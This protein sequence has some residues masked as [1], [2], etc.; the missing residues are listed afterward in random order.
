MRP[1]SINLENHGFHIHK[2]DGELICIQP[3]PPHDPEAPVF[4]GHRGELHQVVWDFAKD[5]LGIP[6]HLG[7]RVMKYFEDQRQA[8]IELDDGEVVTADCVIGADGVRSRARELVLGYVDRPKS[9]GYAIFRAWFGNEKMKA[10]PL[11]RKYCESGDTFQGWI[12]PDVHFLFSTIK[13]GEDCCW[14]LTHKDEKDIEESWSF[15]GKLAD[16]YKVIEGWDPMCKRIVEKTPEDKLVDW[17][18]VYRDPLPRWI[19]GL[20]RIALLGD[21][22]HPFLPTSVQGATQ[23]MEDGVTI[24]VCLRRAGR[25]NIRQALWAY[26]NLRSVYCKVPFRMR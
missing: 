26:Q 4:N 19:S 11:T 15:P 6:I 5:E 13:G 14:V 12:G 2:Y 20:G 1:L 18:L 7:K 8:G 21:S 16:V 17:K 9:S 22:A 24:A 10:D 25:D 3:T 23:A